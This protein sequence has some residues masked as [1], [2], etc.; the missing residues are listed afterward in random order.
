MRPSAGNNRSFAVAAEGQRGRDCV[1]L[2]LVLKFGPFC[3]LTIS[4]VYYQYYVLCMS[5]ITQTYHCDIQ[6]H[7]V[8]LLFFGTSSALVFPVPDKFNA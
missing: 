3:I 2:P 8:F 4:I 5:R 6:R 7:R 1:K